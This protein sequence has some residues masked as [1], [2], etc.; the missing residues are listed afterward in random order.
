MEKFKSYED[1]KDDYKDYHYINKVSNRYYPRKPLN[2]KQLQSYYLQYAKKWGKANSKVNS[3]SVNKSEDMLLYEKILERD[4]KCR[5]LS[6]LTI[7][8]RTI[9][10]D[11]QNGLGSILDGAHVFGK[12]AYPW[13]RYE[14]KNVVIIN[15]FSHSCLDLN[16]SPVDGHSISTDEKIA[17]WK[18]IVGDD[19]KY[20]ELCSRKRN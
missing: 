20:L 6:I 10:N 2:E 16:K 15:R 5:L 14:L 13:M 8:E 17:W 7:S 4:K 12:G 1:F 3:N 18:R 11:H 9:W 19:Y